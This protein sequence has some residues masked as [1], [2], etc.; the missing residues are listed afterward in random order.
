MRA[1]V[2]YGPDKLEVVDVPEPMVLSD[3]G[4]IFIPTE[5]HPLTGQQL[6]LIIGQEF[7]GV[8]TDVGAGVTGYTEGDRVAIEPIYSCGRCDPCQTGTTTYANRSGCMA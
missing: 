3:A 8:I 2:Y 4:P 5:P 7:S 6:P 1:A